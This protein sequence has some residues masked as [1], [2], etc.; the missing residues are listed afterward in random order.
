MSPKSAR[1]KPQEQ[2]PSTSLPEGGVRILQISDCHLYR[3]STGELAGINTLDT[4]DAVLAMAGACLPAPDLILATGDLVHDATPQGYDRLRERLEAHGMPVYCLAG[5]HDKPAVMNSC[6]DSS[7]VGTSKVIRYYDWLIFMLN[8]TIP[9]QEGGHLDKLELE[10]LEG[11]ISENPECHVL[12]C[13]H[14]HPVPVGS[15][16]MDRIALDNPGDLFLI[17][18]RYPQVRGILWGHV[19]QTFEGMHQDIRLM[20][21]PSTC[22]QFLPGH[23]LFGI[24]NLPP[25]TRW[26]ELMPTGVIHSG[27][28]R[29]NQT[30]VKLDLHTIGY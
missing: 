23:D 7:L 17:T 10:L 25:G 15:A 4:F 1:F 20:G 16:W 9:G 28:Q 26:L 6:M 2:T 12:I 11:E 22:I 3:E 30:P 27:V 5:N 13:L 29:L 18:D 8:S 19:H 21:S 14:H 24:D